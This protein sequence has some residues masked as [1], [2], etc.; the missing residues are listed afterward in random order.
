MNPIPSVQ[1]M[2]VCEKIIEEAGSGKKSLINLFTEVRSN[3]LPVSMAMALYVRLT[4][5]EGM[6]VFKVDIVHLQ[7][8]K[9]IASATLP[10]IEST[11]R[12]RPMEVVI[13]IPRIDFGEAGKYEF[14]IYANDVFL[15]H[16]SVDV[17]VAGAKPDASN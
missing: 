3:G 11:D 4:D 5:G 14:Q 13:L 7:T 17:G 1:A 12:L 2:L 8:D 16:S 9:K 15:G 10:G 6:Y